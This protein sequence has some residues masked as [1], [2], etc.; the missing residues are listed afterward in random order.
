M[1][2]P[3]AN[4]PELLRRAVDSVDAQTLPA[5]EILVVVDEPEDG[6]RYGWLGERERCRLWFTGGRKGAAVARNI[7][8]ENATEPFV[9]FLDD[10]DEWLPEKA[11]RQIS[12]LEE[13]PDFQGVTCGNF[14]VY[15]KGWSDRQERPSSEVIRRDVRVWNHTGSFSFFG[16]RR[17]GVAADLRLEESLP[18]CQDLTFYMDF[19]DRG[20]RIGVVNEPL[21]RFHCH[22]GGRISGNRERKEKALTRVFELRGSRMTASERRFLR[23]RILAFRCGRQGGGVGNPVDFARCLALLALSGR[24]ARLGWRVFKFACTHL[25]RSGA[26]N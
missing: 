9:F 14:R 26:K 24:R 7:G 2:I 22:E 12:F 4:R 18:A 20:G 5:G 13:F 23:A 16:F 1:I 17:E 11:A 25:R 19:V 6:D 10:D 3:S 8:L 15:G 21:A